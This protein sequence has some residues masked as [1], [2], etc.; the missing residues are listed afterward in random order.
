[1]MYFKEET[2]IWISQY[3]LRKHY[4]YTREMIWKYLINHISENKSDLE[5]LTILSKIKLNINKSAFN[6]WNITIV[7][8]E[9]MKIII[10]WLYL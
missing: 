10:I 9:T 4:K 2:I 8:Y 1:M 3:I 5:K 6:F 7:I